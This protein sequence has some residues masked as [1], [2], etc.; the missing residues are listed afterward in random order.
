MLVA[1]SGLV[2][3]AL[4]APDAGLLRETWR[5]LQPVMA[6]HGRMHEFVL[7]TNDFEDLAMGQIVKKRSKLADGVQRV[8]T[9]VWLPLD[10]PLMWLAI[11]DD[12]HNDLNEGLVEHALQVEQD[13]SKVLYQRIDLPIP[14]EDRFWVIQITNNAELYQVT[15]Q[16]ILERTWDL[17]PEGLKLL[18]AK[19]NAENE[20][21]VWTPANKGGWRLIQIKDQGCLVLYRVDSDV[22]GFVPDG[23]VGRFTLARMDELIE[24][25]AA[26]AKAMPLHYTQE[27]SRVVLPGGE[28]ISSWPR[29]TQ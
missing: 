15:E 12:Q 19:L 1:V 16:R 20:G 24:R 10:A 17:Y 3:V 13:G 2:Q 5:D 8:D 26:A 18:S 7:E 9:M 28:E 25:M 6:A 4:G 23:F 21:K 29:E 11:H 27:H 22:G 14:F